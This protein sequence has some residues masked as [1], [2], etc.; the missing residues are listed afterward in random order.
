MMFVLTM[1][2]IKGFNSAAPKYRTPITVVK[3]VDGTH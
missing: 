1:P 3:A 2:V